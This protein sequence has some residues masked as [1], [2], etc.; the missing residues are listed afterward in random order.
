[1]PLSRVTLSSRD[2]KYLEI[3]KYLQQYVKYIN[4]CKYVFGIIAKRQMD[5]SE[6]KL[7]LEEDAKYVSPAGMKFL[8]GTAGFRC[9]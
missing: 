7:L 4:T 2:P 5:P 9:K 8:Y 1:M 6:L 3:R